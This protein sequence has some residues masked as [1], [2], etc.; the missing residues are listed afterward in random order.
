MLISLLAYLRAHI[1]TLY[2]STVNEDCH[3]KLKSGLPLEFQRMDIL[4]SHIDIISS[5]F[6]GHL[7]LSIGAIC[8]GAGNVS[9]IEA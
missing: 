6:E 5:E 3:L 1:E 8:F 9:Y 4:S 2:L 7:R